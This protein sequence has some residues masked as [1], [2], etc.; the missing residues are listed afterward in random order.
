[1]QCFIVCMRLSSAAYL[2]LLKKQ[3]NN[4]T[5]HY[6]DSPALVF[7]IVLFTQGVSNIFLVLFK[8]LHFYSQFI[9]TIVQARV[10][11]QIRSLCDKERPRSLTAYWT[12]CSAHG[13]LRNMFTTSFVYTFLKYILGYR[14]QSIDLGIW[15]M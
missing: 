10:G 14:S 5:T 8:K 6:P 4:K 2:H 9:F 11:G 7:L 15:D 13:V 3:T 12:Q 1:M